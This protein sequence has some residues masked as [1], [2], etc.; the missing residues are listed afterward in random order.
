V[1]L[2]IASLLPG[3]AGNAVLQYDPWCCASG[4]TSPGCESTAF[5]SHLPVLSIQLRHTYVI[6][7]AAFSHHLRVPSPLPPCP[8]APLP[9]CPPAP[10]PPCPP[11]PLPPCPPA[12][13]PPCPPAPSLSPHQAIHDIAAR[14]SSGETP[15]QAV[16]AVTHQ[17]L[18]PQVRGGACA[19]IGACILG[20]LT[21][22]AAV[23]AVQWS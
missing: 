5:S 2:Q 14:V 19:E 10:L 12:P 8:P 17:R 6:S 4:I 16:E 13:L 11:A 22:L 21:L 1:L 3:R 23:V 18:G 15:Q 9:P 7:L 20:A